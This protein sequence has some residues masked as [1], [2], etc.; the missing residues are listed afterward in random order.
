MEQAVAAL[1]APGDALAHHHARGREVFDDRLAPGALGEVD[2]AGGV[3]RLHLIAELDQRL[4]HTV[5]GR[6]HVVHVFLDLREACEAGGLHPVREL[7]ECAAPVEHPREPL[8]AESEGF[9][10]PMANYPAALAGRRTS[11]IDE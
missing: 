10:R 4:V 3:T 7:L 6:L 2:R 8:L 11:P 1:G 9:G 5:L